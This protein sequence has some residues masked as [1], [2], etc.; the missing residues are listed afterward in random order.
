MHALNRFT[1][2]TACALILAANSFAST[3]LN[4]DDL[5]ATS[6]MP[7]SYGGLGWDGWTIQGP[8][9]QTIY[10]NG[11]FPSAPN[12]PVTVTSG[13]SH[14]YAPTGSLLNAEGT[15]VSSYVFSGQFLNN[16]SAQTLTITGS[17]QG[18][19]VGTPIVIPLSSSFSYTTL[20]LNGI[21]TLTLVGTGIGPG[22]LID[23]FAFTTSPIPEPTSLILLATGAAFMLARRRRH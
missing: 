15:Y 19:T 2:A 23:N 16:V 17:L 3:I 1:A 4:F 22:F 20:N 10:G 13:V 7:G 12:A 6:V 11:P 9:Y 5:P 8:V 14:I 18:Q 21:D